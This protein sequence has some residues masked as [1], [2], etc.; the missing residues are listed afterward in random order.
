MLLHVRQR[1]TLQEY[2]DEFKHLLNLIHGW[3][4]QVFIAVFFCGLKLD[5]KVGVQF[6]PQTILEVTIR[7]VRICNE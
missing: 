3:P 1:E 4:P 6:Y 5:L 7:V 2:Q